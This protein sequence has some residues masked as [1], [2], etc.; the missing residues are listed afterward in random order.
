M[1]GTAS[2]VGPN[3]SQII[4]DEAYWISLSQVPTTVAGPGRG[5]LAW[6]P[7]TVT[8]KVRPYIA[9]RGAVGLLNGGSYYYPMVQSYVDWYFRHVNGGAFSGLT[10]D[11][12][13]VSGTV[14]DYDVT[15]ATGAETHGAPWYDSSDAYAGTFL[16]LLRRWTEVDTG[17]AAYLLTKTAD[18]DLIATASIATKQPNGLT[19]A[20]PDY[21]AQYL[22]DNV[23]VEAGLRD[24]V[25]LLGNKLNNPTRATYWQSEDTALSTAVETYL[26]TPGPGNMYCWAADTCA[27]SLW[28]RFYSDSVS[29][30]WPINSGLASTS[31]SGSLYT[32]FNASWPNWTTSANNPD[33]SPWAILAVAAANRGDKT[34]VDAYLNGSQTRWINAGRAWPWNVADSADRANAAKK[35]IALP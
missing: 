8:R 14:Y 1:T 33:G 27:N 10:S 19:G 26:W 22:M 4:A 5:G 24:Y 9:N 13:G 7:D 12:A 32:T 6:Y 29:Q 17:A 23:E 16:T 31:R 25:W 15:L 30:V 20:K 34:R 11:Y 21:S 3:Y 2:A 35:A 28:S 18:I